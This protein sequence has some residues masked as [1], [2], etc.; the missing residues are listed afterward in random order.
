MES[1]LIEKL[2]R[3]RY[4]Y[5]LWQTVLFGV[6]FPVSVVAQSARIE[7]WLPVLILACAALLAFVWLAARGFAIGRQRKALNDELVVLYGYKSL[8]WAFLATLT[9]SIAFY[10]STLV[11]LL[12]GVITSRLVCTT[13]IY[14]ALMTNWIAQLIYRRS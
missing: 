5:L 3:R 14:V 12:Q 9:V 7:L 8:M 10:V 11:P 2:D 6:A 13:I 4:K 1:Q